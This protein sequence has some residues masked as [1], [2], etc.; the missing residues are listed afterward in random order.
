MNMLNTHCVCI[1]YIYILFLYDRAPLMATDAAGGA[2]GVAEGARSC[3]QP[4]PGAANSLTVCVCEREREMVYARFHSLLPPPARQPPHRSEGERDS[5]GEPLP[6]AVHPS[7]WTQMGCHLKVHRVMLCLERT[8]KNWIGKKARTAL[9]TNV[10]RHG[11]GGCG[12]A[13]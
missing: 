13:L 1:I 8:D 5:L 6:G 4:P 11:E 9:T 2:A 10:K 12:A 3:L 7:S